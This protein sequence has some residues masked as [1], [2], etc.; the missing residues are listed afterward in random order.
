MRALRLRL[1]LLASLTSLSW[2]EDNPTPLARFPGGGAG[3]LISREGLLAVPTRLATSGPVTVGSVKKSAKVTHKDLKAPFA[4]MKVDGGPFPTLDLGDCSLLHPGEEVTVWT[5]S[6]ARQVTIRQQSTDVA[7]NL[8]YLSLSLPF[9]DGLSGWPVLNSAG[10]AVAFLYGPDPERAEG[11]RAI[12]SQEVKLFLF[13]EGLPPLTPGVAAKNVSGESAPVQVTEWEF[14]LQPGGAQRMGDLLE[15]HRWRTAYGSQG[16]QIAPLLA[17]SL[18][19][20][21]VTTYT[22]SV[23]CLDVENQLMLWRAELGSG[24][25]VTSAPLRVGDRVLVSR[26]QLGDLSVGYLRSGLLLPDLVRDIAGRAQ[27]AILVNAGQTFALSSETS[28]ELWSVPTRF[29]APM[30]VSGN[31]LLVSGLGLVG[32]VDIS[33]GKYHWYRD[34]EHRGKRALWCALSAVQG[35]IVYGIRVPVVLHGGMD[36]QEG[37]HL[38]TDDNFEV[39]ALDIRDGKELWSTE[40]RGTSNSLQ[41]LGPKVSLQGNRLAIVLPKALVTVDVASGKL[42]SSLPRSERALSD[43]LTLQGDTMIAGDPNGWYALRVSDGQRLW[44][45][46]A[47]AAEVAPIW[48]DGVVYGMSHHSLLA[49]DGATGRRLWSH[50]FS[51]RLSGQPALSGGHLYIASMEG[52]IYRLKLPSL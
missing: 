52:R 8:Q 13:N 43:M 39:I 49:I 37:L 35:N 17:D 30:L 10:Q 33:S 51:H 9:E 38:K 21:I 27:N 50:T 2:G 14:P 28:E 26:G 45:C 41:P 19:R 23:Y 32:A 15:L 7:T 3:V 36:S 20:L 12:A 44:S 29:P 16:A 42:V 31:T 24:G 4:L 5:P 18:Q 40:L 1:L 34:Q 47:P 46:P 11:S 48:S 22:G 25:I 6:G